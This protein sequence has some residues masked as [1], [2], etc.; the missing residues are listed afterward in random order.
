MKKKIETRFEP[1]LKL[2]RHKKF[3]PYM[4]GEI[5]FPI[6]VEISPSGVCDAN[7]VKCFYRQNS[8]ELKGHEKEFFKTSRM[9]GLLEELAGLGVDSISWT[10]GGEPT[11]HHSFPKFVEWANWAGLE[12]GLFTNALKPIKYDPSLF[13]WI[14]VT[15]TNQ[16]LNEKSLETLR[17]C[18]TLGICINYGK[19][20]LEKII[21]DTLKIAERLDSLKISK[22]HSTYVQVRPAL[23]VKGRPVKVD[24]PTI[25]H[26]LLKFT[27]YKFLGSNLER[28]YTNCEAYHLEPFIWQN[29]D[30]D[31]CAYHRGEPEFNLGNL[32]SKG[33]QGRFRNIMENAPKTI[34]VVDDCQIC[35]KLNSMNSM[36]YHMRQLKDVNF[37]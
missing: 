5:V 21:G 24:V 3:A 17:Q 33:K 20:D 16:A 35:C 7:C 31:I 19:E 28:D 13:E 12:Q 1:G 10:G 34:K 8:G 23:I 22:D 4:N 2:A 14:R 26:P 18:K 37:P 11:L 30:V 25:E 29:G 27:D 15:K 9:E 32:Y 6:G 36:I